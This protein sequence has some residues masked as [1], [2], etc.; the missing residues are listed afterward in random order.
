[1]EPLKVHYR[2]HKCPPPVPIL[3]QIDPVHTPTPYFLKIH[4]LTNSLA[5]LVSESVLY[6]LIT[7]HVHKSYAPFSLLRLHQSIS[8]RPR[9]TLWLFRNVILFLRWGIVSKSPNTQ[10]GGPHLVGCPR[11]LIQYIHSHPPYWRSFLH[12]QPGDVPWSGDGPTCH[13]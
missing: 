5:A 7:F 9:L 2:I 8:P 10:A 13:S 1:M 6:R 12:P 3:S 11:L 4:R